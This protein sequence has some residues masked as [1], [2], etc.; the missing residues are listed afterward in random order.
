MARNKS[1]RSRG[2]SNCGSTIISSRKIKS[3]GS[4]S[5]CGTRGSSRSSTARDKVRRSNSSNS[6]VSC[7]SGSGSIRNSTNIGVVLIVTSEVA[8]IVILVVVM[9]V[10]GPQQKKKT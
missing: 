7:S 4:R 9:V 5:R 6:Y 2:G 1:S 8:A 10:A 3:C